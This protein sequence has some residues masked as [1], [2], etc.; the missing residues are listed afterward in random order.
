[1]GKKIKSI[2]ELADEPG[3]IMAWL[4]LILAVS[5]FFLGGLGDWVFGAMVFL[6]CSLMGFIR[7]VKVGPSGTSWDAPD[8]D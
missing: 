4:V 3:E 2:F 6:A 7:N 1:M 8:E 5:E